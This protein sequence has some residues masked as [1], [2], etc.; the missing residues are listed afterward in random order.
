MAVTTI[1]N[2]AVDNLRIVEIFDPDAAFDYGTDD[3]LSLVSR[4]GYEL[5]LTGNDFDFDKNDAPTD[6]T[7]TDVFLYDP[8]GDLVGRIDGLS[9]SLEGYYDTVSVDD[10]PGDFTA[11]I[12]SGDDTITGS[13]HRDELEGY[14]GDDLIDGGARSDLIFG[15]SGDDTIQGQGGPDDIDAGSGD[16]RVFGG[17]E[18]DV[19]LGD[20]GNDTIDGGA[21]DDRIAGEAG[22]DVLNGGSQDDDI[23]G[24][25][26]R[27]TIDGGV[28]IDILGGGAGNDKASGGEGSDTLYGDSGND[29]LDGA[30]GVDE[31]YG[32]S[33]DDTLTGGGDRDALFGGS[34][35]DQ[36]RFT[37]P[38]GGVDQILDFTRGDD[39]LVF[40]A[41][42]FDG[43][44]ADFDL[45][46][47]NAPTSDSGTATFLYDV[48]DRAL[49]YDA[50]GTGGAD[51]TLLATL[52]DVTTLDKGDFLIV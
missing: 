27:D 12:L 1:T 22:N 13:E 39:L 6:G 32:G 10:R 47:G 28:G 33:G 40:K 49:S 23:E 21:G 36:F 31:L 45:V 52:K 41:S 50:D 17:D 15:G 25:K 14:A 2:F 16:D 4:D 24:D 35:D 29:R 5:V 20:T 37:S 11:D 7:I 42:G 51:A 34:G 48:D 18:I 38:A 8:F 3:E 44:G 9:A 26:G 46:V 19:I 30:A 43:L